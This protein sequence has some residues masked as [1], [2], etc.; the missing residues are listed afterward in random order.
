MWNSRFAYKFNFNIAIFHMFLIGLLLAAG[1]IPWVSMV[2]LPINTGL[3]LWSKSE[4]ERTQNNK[5]GG[6]PSMKELE[7]A[8]TDCR[9]YFDREFEQKL[10]DA[11]IMTASEMSLCDDN[12]C[13]NCL[14][15]INLIKSRSWIDSMTCIECGVKTN[16]ADPTL[17]CGR[18]TKAY[19]GKKPIPYNS[20]V[21]GKSGN[22]KY[23][24]AN[25][26]KYEE[27]LFH[28]TEQNHSKIKKAPKI[29]TSTG[30]K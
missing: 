2:C 17:L 19:A 5:V 15:T 8:K 23:T 29:T 25:Y 24:Y 11:E 1:T 4:Y 20:G 3:A 7:K 26:D 14:P 28:Y 27:N 13:P 9:V 30:P 12:S 6:F 16:Y 22:V 10:V 18:C 21:G